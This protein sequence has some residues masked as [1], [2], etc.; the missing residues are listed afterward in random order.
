MISHCSSH[1]FTLGSLGKPIS[2]VDGFL[3]AFPA[4][5]F[6]YSRSVGRSNSCI[7]YGRAGGAVLTGYARAT[8][9]CGAW[10]TSL[11]VTAY[12]A[13]LV[14]PGQVAS[15]AG[16]SQ[17]LVMSISGVRFGNFSYPFHSNPKSNANQKMYSKNIQNFVLASTNSKY[18]HYSS[19]LKSVPCIPDVFQVESGALSALLNKHM[20]NLSKWLAV[21]PAAVSAA[22]PD[23]WAGAGRGG[24]RL[25]HVTRPVRSAPVSGYPALYTAQLTPR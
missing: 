25:A 19:H 2:S 10:V 6:A 17:T 21:P 13:G 24:G 22:D 18:F 12:R 7:S 11:A 20:H 4:V 23:S 15:P 8:D 16:S 5:R 9:C 1:N 3:G 14:L